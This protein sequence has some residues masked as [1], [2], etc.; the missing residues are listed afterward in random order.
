MKN[1]KW[2]WVILAVLFYQANDVSMRMLAVDTNFISGALMQALPLVVLSGVMLTKEKGF[3][4][5]KG[6]S[7]IIIPIL[8]YGAIQVLVGNLLY[9]MA[10]RFGGLSVASP[11]VQSQAV[12]A[13]L[14][15][16]FILHEKITTQA[17]I[18]IAMFAVGISML[19]YFKSGSINVGDGLLVGAAFGVL[20]GLSWATGS[21]IQKKLFA[22]HTSPNAIFF[23][24]TLFGMILLALLGISTAKADFTASF[25]FANTY[26]MLIPG[27]FSS[28]ATWCFAKALRDI[29][30]STIIPI[31]SINII[32]NTVIGAVFWNE[33]ISLGTVTGLIMAFAGIVLSQN[34]KL[35]KIR[36]SI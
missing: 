9:F 35:K 33:Y 31:L 4:Q 20:A 17:K 6:G 21:L 2:L 26:K 11:A 18:G 16:A 23:I 34:I 5:Y 13:V 19:A 10:M 24:G 28:A 36:R 27:V 3:V 8:A 29:Q 15:G 22:H 30:M 32:F 12:W 14:L 25:V 1:T 7:K